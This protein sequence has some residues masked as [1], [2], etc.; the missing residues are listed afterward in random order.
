MGISENTVDRHLIT[1][2]HKLTKAV[3]IYVQQ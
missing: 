3:R 1:A 2:L